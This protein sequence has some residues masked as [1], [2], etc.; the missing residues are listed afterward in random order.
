MNHLQNN[1]VCDIHTVAAQAGHLNE[2]E[3]APAGNRGRGGGGVVE[4]M[5]RVSVF[6]IRFINSSFYKMQTE[7]VVSAFA[8][9]AKIK[10]SKAVRTKQPRSFILSWLL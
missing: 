1:M 3:L 7:N 8:G 5:G 10:T 2:T 4:G 9:N 6:L